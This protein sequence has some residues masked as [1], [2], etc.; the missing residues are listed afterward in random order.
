ML[1]S[2]HPLGERSR[3]NRWGL[4]VAAMTFGSVTTGALFGLVLGGAG[5][6]V[7]PMAG[8]GAGLV[9]VGAAAFAS[10]VADLRRL[11][12]P[13]PHRQVDETWIGPYRG[14]VYGGAFGVQLGAGVATYIVTWGVYATFVAELF[15]GSAITGAIIGAAFGAGRALLPLAA[16]WIDRPSRLTTFHMKMAEWA[17]PVARMVGFGLATAGL[18]LLVVAA[19]PV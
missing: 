2:I 3:H 19:L 15:A 16:G 6:A 8:E 5:A 12:I 18:G 9:I 14:W 4:T 17:R 7:L 1:S 11:P 13:G 10:G